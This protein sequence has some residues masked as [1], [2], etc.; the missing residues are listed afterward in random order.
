MSLQ[1]DMIAYRAQKSLSQTKCAE[2]AGVTLQTW[3]M[4]ER[5]IQNPSRVTEAKIRMVIGQEDEHGVQHK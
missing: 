4:V 3:T 5:G 1:N 2:L